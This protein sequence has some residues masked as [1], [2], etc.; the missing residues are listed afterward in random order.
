MPTRAADTEQAMLDRVMNTAAGGIDPE[1]TIVRIWQHTL[2]AI[3]SRNP[4]RNGL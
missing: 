1:R 3:Q 4:H 2:T